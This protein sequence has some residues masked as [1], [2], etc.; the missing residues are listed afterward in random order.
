MLQGW[1]HKVVTILL[2]HDCIGLVGTTL[3]QVWQYQQGCYKLLTASAE[4]VD[5]FWDKQCEHNLLTVCWQTCHK[6][7]DSCVC[8]NVIEYQP[9]L[10]RFVAALT[11]PNDSPLF[12]C[13]VSSC[14]AKPIR[15][16]TFKNKKALFFYLSIN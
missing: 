7:W 6:M 4:L 1:W 16:K 3:Q 10:L 12:L 8:S 14:N 5:N 2:Y 15:C 11:K 13:R 9:W